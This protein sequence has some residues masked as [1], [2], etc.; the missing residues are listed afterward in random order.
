MASRMLKKESY[1][2][3]S[4][5]C[6]TFNVMWWSRYADTPDELALLPHLRLDRSTIDTNS[7]SKLT[8]LNS[9]M[10]RQIGQNL[11]APWRSCSLWWFAWRHYFALIKPDRHTRW[12]KFDNDRVTPVTDKE[13]LE[14]NYGGEVL[15]GVLPQSAAMQPGMQCCQTFH[16]CIYV[17]V[18]SWI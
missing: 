16:K 3:R 15:N 2:S 13:V 17:R 18:H 11:Q 6:Y 9:W 7:L 12:L 14:E 5:L 10:R 4:L 8:R 1:F